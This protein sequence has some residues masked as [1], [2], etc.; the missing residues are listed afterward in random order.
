MTTKPEVRKYMLAA[1]NA[2]SFAD[3][4]AWSHQ[5][6]NHLLHLPQIADAKTFFVFVSVG[7]EIE[8]RILI[9]TLLVCGKQVAVPFCDPRTKHMGAYQIDSLHALQKGFYGIPAPDPVHSTELTPDV[10]D[11]ILVPGIAFSRTG[12]RIGYGGGYYDRF[13]GHPASNALN[14]GLAFGMQ[15]VDTVPIEDYDKPVDLLCCEAGYHLCEK[16]A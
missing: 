15:I 1:R 11:V 16:G 4:R 8:T 10:L 12:H 2:L 7:S 6:V 3:Q 14:V 13:L 5:A 9:D